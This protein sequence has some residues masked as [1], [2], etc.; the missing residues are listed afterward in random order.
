MMARQAT[1]APA[2][3]P[4]MAPPDMVDF[5]WVDCVG[6]GT[7]TGVEE[8]MDQKVVDEVGG[9]VG[10]GDWVAVAISMAAAEEEEVVDEDMND[11]VVDVTLLKSKP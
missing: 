8:E 9:A 4:P 10:C 2:T 6:G 5:R 3:M 1:A 11:E 7:A